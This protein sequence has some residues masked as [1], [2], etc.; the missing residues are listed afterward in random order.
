MSD[1]SVNSEQDSVT[2][3]TEGGTLEIN[4]TTIVALESLKAIHV[5]QHEKTGI[6]GLPG[7]SG[8]D[9]FV[10]AH[11]IKDNRLR[12]QQSDGSWGAW[13]QTGL[14]EDEKLVFS[15]QLTET[16]K[17]IGVTLGAL[18]EGDEV[19]KGT[20]LTALFKAMAQKRIAATYTQPTL[21]L[22]VSDTLVEVGTSLSIELTP[23]FQIKD[24][25]SIQSVKFYRNGTL[26]QTQ[27]TT[28]P[29]TDNGY[30]IGQE[31]VEYSVEVSYADGALKYDTFGDP[32][33]TGRIL[34]GSLNAS[35]TTVGKYKTFYGPSANITTRAEVRALPSSSYGTS[36]SL[37]TGTIRIKFYIAVPVGKTLSNVFDVN[38]NASLK[39]E[40]VKRSD[41]VQL[42]D[43]GGNLYACELFELSIVQAY[44]S[45][46]EH[47]VTLN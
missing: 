40:Y 22:N 13:I 36:F 25:G 35:A 39:S 38:V 46:H 11:E 20:D 43:A 33:A 3:E 8:A 7:K 9:G 16:V 23:V 12:F 6:P 24:A 10:P 32:S 41:I 21:S 1:Y 28:D 27:A 19:L 17:L 47:K 34:A 44:S 4:G 37:N 5:L 29:Y 2:L 45:S 18:N 14:T 30:Q 15:S 26:I 42:T 31:T